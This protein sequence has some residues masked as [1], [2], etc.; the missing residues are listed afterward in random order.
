MRC[1][2]WL[3]ASQLLVVTASAL[4]SLGCADSSTLEFRL[5]EGD[6]AAGKVSFMDLGCT[7]CHEVYQVP[8]ERPYADDAIYV[9]LGGP[10]T[11]V[12]S[13][14]E[15]VTSIINPSHKLSRGLDPRTVTEQGQSRMPNYNDVMQVQQLVDLVAFL[16][17]TYRFY[18]PP[19]RISATVELTPDNLFATQ[20]LTPSG[21]KYETLV[22]H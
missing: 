7:S 4:I 6:A 8:M 11:K 12:K 3:S 9:L 16:Q 2:K 20:E 15:L 19:N 21:D 14:T 1:S 17:P 10:S 13:Y 18:V 22:S 5:P